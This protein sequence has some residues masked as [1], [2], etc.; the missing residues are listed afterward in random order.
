MTNQRPNIIYLFADQ[1]RHDAL[2]CAGNPIV[3]TPHLDRLA[4]EGVRFTRMYCQSPICQP[5]RASVITGLYTHQHGVARNFGADLDPAWPTFMKNLKKAGYTTAQVGKTHFYSPRQGEFKNTP[6]GPEMDLRQFEGFVQSFGFDDVVE[7]FDRYVHAFPQ[8]RLITPYTEHLR[9]KGRLEPYQEQIRSVWRLTPH[10]WDG[11]TSV[12]PQEDDLTCFLADQAI[13]WLRRRKDDQPFFLMLSFVQPHV[14]LMADPIWAAYYQN[15][16]IPRGPAQAP[17][18]AAGVWQEYLE[19][20]LFTHSN[21]HLL[22]DE[23]VLAGARQ[24]Y[25]MV[26]LID[27]RIGDIVKTLEELGLS[28]NTWLIYS[29]DHGEMLG[30]HNLMAKMNFY[31]S[32]VLVPAIIRPPKKTASR[33]VAEPTEA[34]DLT[35]TILDLAGAEP[36]PGSQGRSLLPTLEGGPAPSRPAAFSAIEDRASQ[37]Y[38]VMAA[39]DRYRLTIERNS[40]ALCEFFDL[41]SDPDEM[42]NRAGDPACQGIIRDMVRDCIEPCLALPPVSTAG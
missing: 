8:A 34:I 23:Y 29:A 30:D 22:T 35:A 15:A 28:N 21:S 24:Y 16:D 1:H 32:S 14:P 17:T 13:D 39:T 6:S 9:A 5:A 25:G 31:R 20:E 42:D 2:G 26:S 10:H 37:A 38:F 18:G 11:I 4:E 3:Q 41:A 33:V 36:L 7:E 27:Q 12:L 19:K 40:G